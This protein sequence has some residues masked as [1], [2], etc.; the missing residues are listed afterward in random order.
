MTASAGRSTHLDAIGRFAVTISMV[1]P[2]ADGL[3]RLAS[4]FHRRQIEILQADYRLADG[5]TRMEVIVETAAAR[6]RTVALTLQNLTGVIACDLVSCETEQC[7]SDV[8]VTGWAR[9]GEHRPDRVARRRA[10]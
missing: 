10:G 4:V 9:E 6:A 3:M 1:G 8:A 2:G 5:V 7:E